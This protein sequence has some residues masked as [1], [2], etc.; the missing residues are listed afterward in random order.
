[1]GKLGGQHTLAKYGRAMDHVSLQYAEFIGVTRTK[2]DVGCGE[3]EEEVFERYHW[4][5]RRRRSDR[6]GSYES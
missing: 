3:V 4:D 2:D 5:C 6:H 1:M